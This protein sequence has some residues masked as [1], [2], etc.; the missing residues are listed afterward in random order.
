MKYIIILGDGMADYHKGPLGN[1]TPLELAKKPTIDKYCKLGQI[2]MIKTIDDGLKPGS[3]VANLSVLGYDPRIYYTGRSPLEA[4]S[5][6]IEMSPKDTVFRVNLVTLS[7]NENFA[8]KTMV[9]Y[10]S[11]EISTSEAHELMATVNQK[12]GG[13]LS[14]YGGTSYRNCAIMTNSK[15]TTDFTPPHDISDKAIG[16]YL[17]NGE[18][19][20]IFINL[21]KES[22]EILKNHPVNLKRIAN[23]KNPANCIWFW[24]RGTKPLLTNFEKEYNLKGAMISAVDLLKGIAKGC[25]I[26]NIEVEGAT[27]TVNTNFAGKAKA[28]VNAL[29]DHDY[30]YVHM[31]APDECGHQGDAEGKILSIERIDGVVDYITSELEKKEESFCLAVLPD[32]ATPL[33]LKTHVS[34]PVPFMVYNS[35]RPANCGLNYTEN[36]GQKGIYLDNGR[37]LIKYMLQS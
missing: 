26:D 9:D 18:D 36:E 33:C 8:D 4:L 32:H 7:D 24:G 1:N 12:L 11:G 19:S 34:D 31:E 17:P 30:V 23:G 14:F 2:G 28:C 16:T 25:G 3:D 15:C 35:L 5:I 37:A 21:M 10:S 20:D 29:S 13:L 6:G 22:Y 27:G